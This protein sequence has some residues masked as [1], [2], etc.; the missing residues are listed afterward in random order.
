MGFQ[1]YL[2]VFAQFKI[3]TLYK[4][5]NEKDFFTFLSMLKNE[6]GAVLDIGA[7]IGIMTYHL[8]KELPQATIHS[9]EPI[10]DNLIVLKQIV[11]KFNLKNVEIHPIAIGNKKETLKMILPFNGKTKMQGLSHVKHDTITDW[12]EGQEF[13]VPADTLDCLFPKEK[14]AGI[15]IDIENFEYFAFI[16]GKEM[17]KKNMPLIYAELWENENRTKCFDFLTSLG[18]SIYI[19]NNQQLV[20]FNV[21]LH[22]A[23]NFIFRAN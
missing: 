22:T 1:K 19:V 11:R 21:K 4:D 10:P 9:F 14:I 7:N 5:N 20:E 6:E 2:Y 13:D 12:N 23:Q 16:G 17:L 3:R 15:K 8:S 18:Y